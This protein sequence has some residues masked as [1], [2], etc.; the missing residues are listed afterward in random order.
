GGAY[1]GQWTAQLANLAWYR[2]HVRSARL[3]GMSLPSRRLDASG[4]VRRAL[5]GGVPLVVRFDA[6]PPPPRL[7]PLFCI[8]DGQQ[9]MIMLTGANGTDVELRVRQRAVHARL[10][11]PSYRIAGAMAGVD[12]GPSVRMVGY[13]DGATWCVSVDGR[14]RCGLGVSPGGGWR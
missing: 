5:L 7:A 14:P 13:R 1:W 6:G 10:V 9:H 8:L 2:G 4:G 3:S 11:A 12:V